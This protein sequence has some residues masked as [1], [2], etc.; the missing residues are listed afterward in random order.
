MACQACRRYHYPPRIYGGQT[1]DITALTVVCQSEVLERGLYRVRVQTQLLDYAAFPDPDD[2]DLALFLGESAG[3][4]AIADSRSSGDHRRLMIGVVG[5][6][7]HD[8]E[9]QIQ[10]GNQRLIV[11]IP[12]AGVTGS[13]FRVGASMTLQPMEIY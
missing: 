7:T 6:Y 13:A 2:L 10:G 9:L 3:M 4:G 1:S 5:P 8:F 12:S 11:A